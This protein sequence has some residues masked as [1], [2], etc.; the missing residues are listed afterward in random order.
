MVLDYANGEQVATLGLRCDPEMFAVYLEPLAKAY[1]GAYERLQRNQFTYDAEIMVERNNHG[2]AVIL[3]LRQ[4]GAALLR[5]RTA[6]S[7]GPRPAPANT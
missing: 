7:A 1:S 2:H 6:R 3:A 4:V 5:G